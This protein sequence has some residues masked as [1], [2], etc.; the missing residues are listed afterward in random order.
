MA[1]EKFNESDLDVLDSLYEVAKKSKYVDDMIYFQQQV[2]LLIGD[3]SSPVD[4]NKYLR[5]IED[6]YG[7]GGDK[8]NEK[9]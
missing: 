3:L 6:I 1:F 4:W 2:E 8:N 9:L 5:R 7:Y